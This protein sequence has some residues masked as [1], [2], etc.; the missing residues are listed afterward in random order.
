MTLYRSP[1]CQT[2]FESIGLPIQEKKFISI[3]QD[4]GCG[5]HL[6]FLIGTS[7]T[8]FALQV[9]PIHPI[10]FPVKWPFGSGEEVRNRFASW[11]P[12]W[13]SVRNKFS[14]FDLQV[15]PI[16][17]TKFRVNWPFSSGEE[18]QDGVYSGHSGFP[19]LTIFAIFDLEVTSVFLTKFRV[20]WPFRSEVP[21]TRWRRRRQCWISDGNDFLIFYQQVTPILPI[22]FRDLWPF[23]SGEELENRFSKWKP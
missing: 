23:G 3:F 18:S 14:V 20:S 8:S 1:E 19:I 22:K 2:N 7:L 16:L 4:G 6:G 9:T 11:Q 15:A 17:S 10:K 13:I 12:S 5:S 21:N